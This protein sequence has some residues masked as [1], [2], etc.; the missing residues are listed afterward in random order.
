MRKRIGLGAAA[1]LA[2]A[3]A[4]C[5]KKVEEDR[6]GSGEEGGG[7]T[8]KPP[9]EGGPT[10]AAGPGVD[11]A[12]KV[13]RIGAL[14]DQSGPAAVIGVQFSH[15]ARLLAKVVNEGGSGF[16]PEGWTVEIVEKDHQYNPQKAVQE[17]NAIKDDV[18]YIGNS[19]GT[20]TTL[21]LREHLERDGMIAFPASLSSQ[22][23]EH[24]HTPP[25]GPSYKVEAMRAM[26]W[27]VED[28]GGAA[29]VRAA[30]VYQRD[31]FGQDA[32]AGWREAARHHGVEIVAEQTVDPGQKDVT[33]VVTAL[34]EKKANY[35]LLSVLP[36]GA[37]PVLGTAAATKFQARWIG[38]TPAWSDVFFSDRSPLP[39]PVFSQFVWVTGLTYWGEDRPGMDVFLSA[40]DKH[41]KEF[42]GTPDFYI[43]A[44]YVSGIVQLEAARRAIENG[45]ITRAGYRKALQTISGWDAGGLVPPV[46]LSKTPY[47]TGTITRILAPDFENKSWKQVADY[48]EPAALSGEEG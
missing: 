22:M 33:A 3:L 29:D 13:I 6:G 17:Y 21:P 46:D 41:G 26:D 7:E 45:D 8:R 4:G 35:V 24:A 28:A 16:L 10:L 34:R 40:W 15:G 9:G 20:P 14:N 38:N 43:M 12:K 42:G 30:I 27:A 48:A 11:P 25:I 39:A 2:L 47:V 23:A 37:G 5:G 44:A 32:L 19:F 31:D 18:L 36:T 1:V